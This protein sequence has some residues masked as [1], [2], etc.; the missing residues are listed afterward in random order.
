MDEAD[1]K[2]MSQIFGCATK[3][4]ARRTAGGTVSVAIKEDPP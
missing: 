3:I 2:G 4:E 1:A